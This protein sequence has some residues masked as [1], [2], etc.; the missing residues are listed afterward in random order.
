MRGHAIRRFVLQVVVDSAAIAAAVIILGFITVPDPFPFGSAS[1]PI[2]QA[3]NSRLIYVLLSG[4]GL[5]IGNIIL[6]PVLVAFTGRLIIWS[7]GL[8]SIV[9]T[10]IILYITGA[11]TPLTIQIADPF[12]VWL[13]V[14]AAIVQVVGATFSALMGLT[15]PSLTPDQATSGVWGFLD[16]LPTPRRNAIIENLRLQQVYDTLISFG[17][18]ITIDRTPLRTLRLWS[19]KYILAMPDPVAGMTTP[20]KIAVMLQQ[21]G[22]TYVKIGQMAASQGASFPTSGPTSS[23][24]CRAT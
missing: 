5:T 7:M 16:A 21:L 1:V 15:R 24:A 8:F 20:Q 19:E 22:P 17:V 4:A 12:I 3:E 9:L 10:A 18:E 13:L 6:R 23:R 2:A 14:A 11:I